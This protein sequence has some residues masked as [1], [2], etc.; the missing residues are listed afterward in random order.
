MSGRA[1]VCSP[2]GRIFERRRLW[3]LERPTFHAAARLLAQAV[4]EPAGGGDGGVDLVVGVARG[5]QALAEALAVSLGV[6]VCMIGARHNLTDAR[7]LQ[8]SGHVEVDLSP[9]AAGAVAGAR[10]LVADDICGTGA[11]LQAVTHQLER[12]WAAQVRTCTLCRNDGAGGRPL[13]DWWV[14]DVRD[15]VAFPWEPPPSPHA[16]TVAL[17]T[18]TRV[19]TC[20][21]W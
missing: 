21:R 20:R 2:R 18:P 19:R 1:G 13:P 3:R 12:R 7:Y 9:L 11:T 10:C 5:G 17:P 15:W 6:G 16:P 8:A 14:W 4:V